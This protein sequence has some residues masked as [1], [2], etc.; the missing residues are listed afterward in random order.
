MFEIY[1]ESSSAK[2]GAL[3][4]IYDEPAG[5]SLSPNASAC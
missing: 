1:D 3:F 5:E 2:E 4:K